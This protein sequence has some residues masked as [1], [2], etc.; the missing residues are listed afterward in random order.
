M[1]TSTKILPATDADLTTLGEIVSIANLPDTIIKF[2]FT[3]WPS[4]A[5]ISSFFT[6]RLQGVFSDPETTVFKIVDEAMDEIQGSVCLKIESNITAEDRDL[7]KPTDDF[8]PENMNVEFVTALIGK[9]H[10]LIVVLPRRHQLESGPGKTKY[11]ST[12]PHI[13]SMGPV[14][15]AFPREIR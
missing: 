4:L 5:S 11:Y 14:F 8:V 2:S 6:A 7:L 12:P 3:D 13:S 10:E 15:Q 1:S 9:L